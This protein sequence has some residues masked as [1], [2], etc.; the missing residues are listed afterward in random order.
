MP[1]AEAARA[2]HGRDHRRHRRDHSRVAV[3]LRAG[4]LHPRHLRGQ[5]FQQFAVAV[6]VSMVISAINA[7]TL[8]PALCAIL[9]KP[10][11]GP[12]RGVLGWMS[13]RIDGARDGYVAGRR[14]DRPP[15]GHRPAAACARLRRQRLAVPR[16]ADRLPAQRGPGRILR[17]GAP[18]RGLRRSTAPT[19][20]MRQVETMLAGIDGVAERRHRHRLQLPRRPR[21]VELAASPSSRMKPFDE[22]HGPGASIVFAAIAH[23]NAARARRSARR[24]SSPSTCR[25]SSGSAPARASSTSCST[26]RAARRPSSP[27]VAGGLHG[28]GQPGSA[29][30]PDLHHLFGRARRSSISTSTA[31]G[32]RPSAYRS[33]TS[34]PRCRARWASIYV[35]DFNLFGRTWQVNMQARRG[36]PR[37]RSPISTGSTCAM[38]QG[39][40]VPVSAVAKRRVSSSA[41]SPSCDTTTTAR[42]R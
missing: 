33:A 28:C 16:G 40:M 27:P 23:G 42:S 6:S 2:R 29:A 24:R 34:S 8:S 10:H 9:L 22:R 11:H 36:R 38:P 14:R 31:S 17:R 37:C 19:R 20:S 15:R 3:G 25:R 30:R 13:R 35:N 4:R 1:A 21:Q 26:S 5:L 32:C 39:G 41:R 12:K 7:L 18:A